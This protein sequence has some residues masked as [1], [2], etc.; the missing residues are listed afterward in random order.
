MRADADQDQP[1]LLPALVRFSSVARARSGSASL[2]ALGSFN[3]A[4]LTARAVFTSSSVRLRMNTG[5][6]RHITVM[7]CPWLMGE[8]STSMEASACVEASGFIWWMKGHRA[9]A[10]PTPTKAC[11]AMTIKSRR[12]GSSAEC[13]AKS[14]S[15]CIRAPELVDQGENAAATSGSNAC[16]SLDCQRTLHAFAGP[17]S[18]NRPIVRDGLPAPNWTY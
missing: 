9:T 8:R 5:L 1:V 14:A 4:I 16:T 7:A 11:A 3:S 2:R 13:D 10:A 15:F 17:V 6:P 12:L 18:R